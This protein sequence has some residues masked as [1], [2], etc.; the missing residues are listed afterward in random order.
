MSLS[1]DQ[2]D[3]IRPTR[4]GALCSVPKFVEDRRNLDAKLA[5]TGSSDELAFLFILWRREND[6]VFD[7]ALHLP[8]V[9]RMRLSN[10]DHQKGDAAAVLLIKLI[11]SGNLPPEGRSSVAS[12]NEDDGLSLVDLGELDFGGVVE[13]HQGEVRG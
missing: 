10:V 12:E 1:V 3:A 2:I 8:N 4:I 6:V 11:E 9:A 5:H 7:V 13:L